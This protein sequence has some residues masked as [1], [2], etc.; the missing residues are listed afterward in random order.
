MTRIGYLKAPLASVLIAAGKG[1]GKFGGCQ[2]STMMVL[3][4]GK[5]LPT[6]VETKPGG[7]MGGS[8]AT[9]GWKHGMDKV[10]SAPA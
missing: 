5:P 2:F 8:S 3:L 9:D 4:A 1:D 6:T 7:P 10:A